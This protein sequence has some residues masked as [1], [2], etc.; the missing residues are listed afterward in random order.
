MPL[1]SKLNIV[2]GNVIE[3]VDVYQIVDALTYQEAYDLLIKGSVA[4]GSGS[5]HPGAKLYISGNLKVDGNLGIQAPEVNTPTI[6]YYDT[7]SGLFS[8]GSDSIYVPTSSFQELLASYNSFTQSYYADSASFDQRFISASIGLTQSLQYAGRTPATRNVG[9]IVIGDDLSGYSLGAL[10]EQIISPYTPPTISLVSLSPTSS[11]YNQQNVVYNVTF[12]WYQNVGTTDF[13]SAQVQYKRNLDM[14]WT[15]LSTTVTGGSSQKDAEATVTLN[16]AGINNDAV[17]FRCVFVDTQTNT[18]DVYTS[19]FD[20]YA[21]PTLVLA[22]VITPALT[23]GGYQIRSVSTAYTASLEGTFYR[24]SPN[25]NLSQYKIARDY[26][27]SSWTDLNSLTSIAGAG[28]PILPTVVDAGQPTNKNSV[29]YIGFVTDAQVT[30]GQ[31]VNYITAFNIMQPVL[32]GMSSATN[33]A[34]VDLSQ[35]STVPH[36]TITYT[37]TA[38]D[39]VANGLVF[40]A[41]SNRF[42][43]AFDNSYGTLNTFFDTSANLNLISNFTIGTKSVTFAD[44]TT[45]TYTVALYNLVVV[46]GTYTVNIA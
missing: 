10:I 42:C 29:R 4:I 11:F 41:S 27:D 3:D 21:A 19:T 36:G 32:Y 38:A 44:G 33:I 12:R 18:S 6:L 15:N 25:V 26:G 43:V 1:L 40:N 45:K 5:L 13:T 20:A 30:A 7:A 17:L 2:N 28:G 22:P 37:N 23:A 31:Y 35:L 24:N 46:S 8:Y 39:K 14:V 34:G 9:G 16:T